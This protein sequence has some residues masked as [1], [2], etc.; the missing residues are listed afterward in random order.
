MQMIRYR[1]W[2][3][4]VQQCRVSVHINLEDSKKD[5]LEFLL[6]W[7]LFRY[8]VQ[9]VLCLLIVIPSY[10]VSADSMSCKKFK[11]KVATSTSVTTP[12]SQD[13]GKMPLSVFA[14]ATRVCLMF[15]QSR[16]LECAVLVPD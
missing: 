13:I 4:N 12:T 14:K 1:N 16:S 7:E 5:T 9:D 15:S 8:L 6:G 11:V 10:S 2:Q 3:N